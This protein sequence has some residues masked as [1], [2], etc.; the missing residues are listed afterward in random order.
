MV[1]VKQAADLHTSS[2][3]QIVIDRYLADND[4]DR[5]VERIRAAYGERCGV[6]EE[7]LA[8]RMPEG[9]RWTHPEGGMFLWVTGPEGLD[10]NALLLEALKR[11]VAFVPGRDFFPDA[12]GGNCMRLNFSNSKPATIREGIAR[13]A[14]LCRTAL[15]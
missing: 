1:I 6:M 5:H 9:F 3:D 14:D 12:T 2:L 8:S 4:N 13:L 15:A 10:T 11:K 7:E